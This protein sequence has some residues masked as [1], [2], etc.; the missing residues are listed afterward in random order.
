[1]QQHD[2][3]LHVFI[4][5]NQVLYGEALKSLL[6]E[7][8]GSYIIETYALRNAK[9]Q[10]LVVAQKP[11]I[12][13]FDMDNMSKNTWVILKE[14]AVSCKDARIIILANSNEPIYREYAIK[15]GA[16]GFIVKSS[17]KE[18]L[19][20]AMKIVSKGSYFFDPGMH[21]LEVKTLNSKLRSHFNL[22][23]REFEIIQLIKDGFSTKDIA[24]H[25][26]LSFH[27]IESHRKNI[28]NKLKVKK[29]TE[30]LRLY[31]NFD[32]Y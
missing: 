1:M 21:G 31:N 7:E 13:L 18:L 22:S 6:R 25:L 10:E 3:N 26:M 9:L 14:M 2:S 19:T 15:Y 27:T 20:A 24:C 4:L 23:N 30:L 16:K 11:D 8:N 12:I 32:S 5:S 28:Y 29:V 17:P